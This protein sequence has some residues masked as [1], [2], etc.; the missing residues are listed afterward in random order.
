M[1]FLNGPNLEVSQRN[2][3]PLLVLKQLA[4]RLKLHLVLGHIE[5]QV[6]A[7]AVE[8]AV[9]GGLRGVAGLVPFPSLA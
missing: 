8:L 5:S 6:H 1:V 3:F 9:S 7:A 4:S 2:N